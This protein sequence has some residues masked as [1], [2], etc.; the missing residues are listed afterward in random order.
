MARQT[1]TLPK[2][3]SPKPNKDVFVF[4][5]S[6][7]S[8]R[9][10]PCVSM[11]FRRDFRGK[12]HDVNVV[13]R[14]IVV[15]FFLAS[16]SLVTGVVEPVSHSVSRLRDV[17][18]DV[19]AEA[20]SLSDYVVAIR[21][22]LH[23]KPELMWGEF[24]TSAVVKR[25]LDL[26]NVP[27]EDIASPGVVG[28]VG[29]GFGPAVLLRADMDAL[30]VFEKSDPAFFP[31]HLRSQTP[32]VMHACGHDGHVAMLLGA[33]KLL[34][35][36]EGLL[37]G[38]V[39]LAF[40]PA[41]EGGAGART[42]L[43][44][45]LLELT[46]PINVAFAIHNWPYPSTKSGVIGTRSGVIMAGSAAFEILVQQEP[47]TKD[48]ADV[49]VCV[50]SVITA[51]QTFT[52]RSTDPLDSALITVAV[53]D[54]S[55]SGN[56]SNHGGSFSHQFTL[57]GASDVAYSSTARLLGQF[58]CTDVYTFAN[59]F[60]KIETIATLAGHTHGCSVTV[61]F[62]PEVGTTRVSGGSGGARGVSG[63]TRSIKRAH[64]PP[65]VNDPSVVESVI[66]VATEM[67]GANSVAPDVD[68]VMPGEDFGFFAQTW[69]SAMAWLGTYSPEK[70][71]CFP[72]TAPGTYST[73]TCC[74]WGSPC[75]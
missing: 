13:M 26:M 49:V 12:R 61:D 10:L 1:K 50:A 17:D 32:G 28:R 23:Q 60:G 31:A 19:A 48:T 39:Y 71:P 46:P 22:E 18:V 44:S 74:T 59:A 70:A 34:K 55:S 56:S 27:Y 21:R 30:P 41:E 67:F 5:Q 24:V 66:K 33:A 69:P 65:T 16:P 15:V 51:L 37:N 11:I 63:V 3:K 4:N 64:Y 2:T 25:E 58:H 43:E 62:E 29:T 52:S 38:T 42:M 72:C 6:R 73:K 54:T 9:A 20:E 68:P 45:G 7:P 8:R 53:V 47:E 35:R 40:Q 14:L 36:H 75:T 57:P